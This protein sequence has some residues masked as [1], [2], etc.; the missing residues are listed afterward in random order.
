MLLFVV[1]VTIRIV[2]SMYIISNV[3]TRMVGLRK[4]LSL[5]DGCGYCFVYVYVW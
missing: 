1:Y 3:L 2:G 5:E 4:L